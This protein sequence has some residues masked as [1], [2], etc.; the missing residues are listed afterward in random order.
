MVDRSSDKVVTSTLSAHT[1]MILPQN[2]NLV[3]TL[4]VLSLLCLGGWVSLFKAAGG[5]RFELFY[6]DFAF[7]V[8]LTAVI[9]SFTLGDLGYDGFTFF[10]DVQHAGKRQLLYCLAAG[11]IFNLGNM[12]LLGAVSIAGISV[13][14]P[15][16]LGI[17]VLF[18]AALG[19]LVKSGGNPALVALGCALILAAVIVSA[20]A[21]RIN[22]VQRHEDLARAGV[23][24]STRRPNPVKGILIALVGGILIGSIGGLMARARADDVGLG[25]Y[26]AAA[27]FAV[28][29]FFSSFVFDIFFVNLPVDGE[30]VEFTVYLKGRAVQHIAGLLAGV[31]WFGGVLMWMVATTVPAALQPSPLIRLLLSQSPPVLAALLGIVVW[32]EVKGGDMRVKIL[33]GLMIAFFLCGL[34]M[35][36]LSAISTPTLQ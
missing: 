7:G 22:A 21:Y 33:A 4:M 25:P 20:M 12:F 19:V 35:I 31:V 8:M 5:W 1:K 29:V 34:T 26:A 30:P 23:A 14:F 32:N 36:G 18:S 11:V 3:L 17:G 15:I 10:D 6:L 9:C 13:A 2:S 16:S 28:G 27:I 24:K